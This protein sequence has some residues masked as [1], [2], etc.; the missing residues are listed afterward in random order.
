MNRREWLASAGLLTGAGL[1]AGHAKAEE[2][3]AAPS[4]FRYCLNTS[5][6]RG[7]KLG[8]VKEIEIAAKAGYDAIEPWMRDL[9]EYVQKGGSL[10]DLGMQIADGGLTVESAIGFAQWIVDD[11]NERKKQARA[12]EAG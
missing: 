11:P 10:R 8:I 2:P 9:D 7:K 4:K 1:L 3:I 6:I 12:R 5:T